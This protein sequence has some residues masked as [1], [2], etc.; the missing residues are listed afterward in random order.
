V[1]STVPGLIF[2]NGPVQNGGFTL[3]DKPGKAAGIRIA[4]ALNQ[5]LGAAPT[6]HLWNTVTLAGDLRHRDHARTSAAPATR[7]E[8]ERQ[9]VAAKYP[10]ATAPEV[11]TDIDEPVVATA[12]SMVER[13]LATGDLSIETIEVRVCAACGHV[14]GLADRPCRACGHATTRPERGRQLLARRQPGDR[15]V[16]AADFHAHARRAPAHLIAIAA[17]A[18]EVLLLSRT[19][20]HGIGLDELGLP[21]L[22]LDPRAGLHAAV[23]AVAV[24]RD[25][26]AEQVVMTT[27]ENAAANIAAYGSRFR[28]HQGVRLRYGLHGRIPYD[29][30]KTLGSAYAAV[31]VNETARERFENWFL[32]LYSWKDKNDIDASQLPALLRLFHR[33]RLSPVV[34]GEAAAILRAQITAGDTRWLTDKR[35]VAAAIQEAAAGQSA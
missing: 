20:D 15:L 25:A 14:A 29:Q 11:W 12:L 4:A 5:L 27:T 32:P 6:P 3:T 23:L 9:L 1:I 7:G 24:N 30:V 19:R 18:P 17:D 33:A 16:V 22:V 35:L 28:T 21:G 8:L 2:A 31:R 10:A 26:P 34:D 13:G